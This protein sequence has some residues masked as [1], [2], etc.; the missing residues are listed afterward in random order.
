MFKYGR[1][2]Y[3]V[4]I[5]QTANVSSQSLLRYVSFKNFEIKL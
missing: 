3:D 2:C 5:F 4:I 1:L